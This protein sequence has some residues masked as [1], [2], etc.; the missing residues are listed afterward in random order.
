MQTVRQILGAA[1]LLATGIGGSRI[2]AQ[3]TA[4]SRADSPQILQSDAEQLLALANQARAAIGAGPLKWDPALAAA[5]LQHCLRMAQEGPIS[6]Q[7]PGEADLAVRAGQSGAHFNVVEENIASGTGPTDPLETHQG[8]MHSPGHRAN[9]LN[10]E[11]DSAGIAVVVRHGVTYSVADYS[12]AVAALSQDEVE[13]A[14]SNLLRARGLSIVRDRTAARAY[15]ALPEGSRNSGFNNRPGY[16]MRWQNSDP[17][18]LPPEFLHIL[19]SGDYT[20][21]EVGSCP[22]QGVEELFTTYRVAVLLFRPSGAS[23]PR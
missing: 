19:D 3:S 13:A 14:V 21:A 4:D 1:L 7:Y 11:V 12:R 17:A 15:C 5:A 16:R 22:P 10:R 18:H 2:N 8:W 23:Q 6:H 9:L 20:H